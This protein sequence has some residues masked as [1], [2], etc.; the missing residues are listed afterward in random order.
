MISSRFNYRVLFPLFLFAIY[1]AAI[2][3]AVYDYE[4][5]FSHW[6]FRFKTFFLSFSSSM[7]TFL[8]IRI[9]DINTVRIRINEDGIMW[10]FG[11][12]G[13]EKSCLFSEID[14]YRIFSFPLVNRRYEYIVIKKDGKRIF[15]IS[16]FYHSNY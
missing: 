3:M 9:V 16:E 4:V 11:W 6:Q 1:L 7:L 14:G 8:V 15:N 13:I 10:N 5:F 2:F 12:I